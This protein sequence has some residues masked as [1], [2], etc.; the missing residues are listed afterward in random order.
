MKTNFRTA[1]ESI[2]TYLNTAPAAPPDGVSLGG[3]APLA[4]VRAQLLAALKP[5]D[6]LRARLAARI[7]LG[8]GTDPL[9]PIEAGPKY[10]QPM[11]APLAQLS[12]EWMLPGISDVETDCATLLATNPAFIEAYMV[13]LNDGLSREL[14]WR[15][16]PADRTV[17]FFQNF[18]GAATPD[19]DPI[20]TFDPH[21]QLGGHIG[22]ASSTELVLL[23]RAAL[24]QRYPN[25]M[26]YAAEAKWVNG[27]RSLSDHVE[28]P[29]F[30]GNFGQDVTFF[31][32]NLGGEDPTGSDDPNAGKPGWY[33]V[34]AEH[35]TEPRVGLEPQK[36]TDPTCYWNDLS[37][38]EVK[39]QGNYIDV[40]IA[41]PTPTN[42]SIGW[43]GNSA[44]LGFILMR[45]PVRVALHAR[46]LLGES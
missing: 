40:S 43:R 29:V 14:L 21:A 32:F 46:S 4:P 25:A 31:G 34:V 10:P 27:V 24:F 39:L 44:A 30:R 45:R 15:E 6:T 28:Y 11:Y 12:P 37:W 23:I 3:Q 2:N 17:T 20:N 9:Q 8:T 41:P 35:V 7:P 42:E 16:F 22:G 26:V 13:G 36:K 1:A 33:F 19:I 18:W 5:S 38:E